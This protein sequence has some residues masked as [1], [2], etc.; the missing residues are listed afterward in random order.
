M[1][2][3]QL[4]RFRDEGREPLLAIFN[5]YVQNY[6]SAYPKSPVPPPFIDHLM[7]DAPSTYIAELSD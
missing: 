2:S 3:F 5:H 7:Q 1:K 4:R 6:F